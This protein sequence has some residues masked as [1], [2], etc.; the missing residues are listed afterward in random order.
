MESEPDWHLL[1][2]SQQGNYMHNIWKQ[3]LT[4]KTPGQ[5]HLCCSAVFIILFEYTTHCSGFSTFDFKHVNTGWEKL[6]IVA[7]LGK[8]QTEP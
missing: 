8:K 7:K 2:Q 3:Q 5:D 4:V 1:V 6:K